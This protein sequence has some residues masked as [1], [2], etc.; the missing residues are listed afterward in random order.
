MSPEA[1]H[2]VPADYRSDVWSLGCE[3][4]ARREK[5]RLTF[6]QMHYLSIVHG[7]NSFQG[8]WME[9]RKKEITIVNRVLV[10]I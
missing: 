5:C 9:E 6:I 4:R 8:D 10:I 2:G 1:I 7:A 3:K